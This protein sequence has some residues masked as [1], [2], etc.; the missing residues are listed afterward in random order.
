M[1]LDR[2][3]QGHQEGHSTSRGSSSVMLFVLGCKYSPRSKDAKGL[4][5][6]SNVFEGQ[7]STS[8]TSNLL[9]ALTH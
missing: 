7:R 5:G 9:L 2:R 6:L 1:N 4:A 3:P 8:S